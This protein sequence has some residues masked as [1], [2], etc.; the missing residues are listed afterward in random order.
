M[1]QQVIAIFGSQAALMFLRM[2]AAVVLSRLVGPHD[3]GV[4]V[5]SYAIVVFVT[6][7]VSF[8]SMVSAVQIGELSEAQSAKLFLFHLMLAGV[9]FPVVVLAGPLF[10]P[11]IIKHNV[12]Y[13]HVLLSTSLVFSAL[14]TQPTI[15]ALRNVKLKQ[16]AFVDALSLI[17]GLGVAIIVA[18]MNGGAEGRIQAC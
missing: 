14:R 5:S 16:V 17:C 8:G 10:L 9:S 3:Y 15:I 12:F 1:F 2:A 4:F 11:S 13:L 18:R 7:F 6:P